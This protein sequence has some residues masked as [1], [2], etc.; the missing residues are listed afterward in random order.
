MR[1]SPALRIGLGLLLA[2]LALARPPYIL[3]SL[4]I[5]LPPW[6]AAFGGWRANLL[7][8][9]VLGLVLAWTGQFDM[10]VAR[11]LRPGVDV[12][13]RRQL[14]FLVREP[15][16]VPHIIW[17]TLLVDGPQLTR[18]MMGVLGWLNIRLPDLAYWS[19]GAAILLAILATGAGG[20]DGL[21]PA[22]RLGV[23]CFW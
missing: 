10:Q 7:P 15:S 21:P 11:W 9:L 3:L 19:G 12:D 5:L 4:I 8:V 18:E 16:A 22:T 23:W 1:A 17:A 13:M 6:R 14:A 20:E 2:A